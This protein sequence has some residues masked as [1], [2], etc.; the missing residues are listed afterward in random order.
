MDFD[1]L[2][3]KVQDFFKDLN[4]KIKNL[5]NDEKIAWGCIIFGI[6]LII[7]ALIVW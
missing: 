3:K 7:I 1:E 4:K 5:P 2:T 6:L